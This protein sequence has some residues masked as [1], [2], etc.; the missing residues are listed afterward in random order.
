MLRRADEILA[1]AATPGE[2]R[3]FATILELI[4]NFELSDENGE[5]FVSQ[6]DFVRILAEANF[7]ISANEA[8]RLAKIVEI[9][10]N[11][12]FI[13]YSAFTQHIKGKGMNLIRR[14]VVHNM[15]NKL[16]FKDPKVCDLRLLSEVFNAKNHYDVKGGKKS[17]N[18]V[19]EEF[20]RAVTIFIRHFN[21]ESSLVD[22]LGFKTF[23]DLVSPSIGPDNHFEFIALQ[24][25]WFNKLPRKDTY[26]KSEVE[27]FERSTFLKKDVPIDAVRKPD[28]EQKDF[29]FADIRE[30]LEESGPIFKK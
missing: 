5:G 17:E 25:F 24:C 12:G 10:E 3:N 14:E 15:F 9:P 22:F 19:E 11:P 13:D 7:G 1:K 18:K 16:N 2:E 21:K 28:P 29:L 27:R 8:S 6:E 30:N 20:K 26:N 4:E 23:W